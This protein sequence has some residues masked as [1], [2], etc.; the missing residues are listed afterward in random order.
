MHK[1]LAPI[2]LVRF[3]SDS[4]S[5]TVHEDLKLSSECDLLIEV[6]AAQASLEGMKKMPVAT[7]R[8][9]PNQLLASYS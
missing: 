4:R 7:R 5:E 2:H 8:N 3:S 1:V 9:S 6:L